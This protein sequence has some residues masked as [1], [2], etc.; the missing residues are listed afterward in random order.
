[1]ASSV[2]KGRK[3]VTRGGQ[4]K[5]ILKSRGGT[6]IYTK[7]QGEARRLQAMDR[8]VAGRGSSSKLAG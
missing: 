3:N 7:S 8:V 4:F 1:M 2:S 6:P 5:V